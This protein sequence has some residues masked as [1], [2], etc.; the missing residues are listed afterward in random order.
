MGILGR[1]YREEGERDGYF[2]EK[3][4]VNHFWELK[5]YLTSI[6]LK[7]LFSDFNMW[8]K[9]CKVLIVFFKVQA[10]INSRDYPKIFTFPWPNEWDPK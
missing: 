1:N 5:L 2:R 3:L 10:W 9:S 6:L 4:H 8:Y 7:K